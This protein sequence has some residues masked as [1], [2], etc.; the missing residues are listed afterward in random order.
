MNI[1]ST[2]FVLPLNAQGSNGAE[3][4]ADSGVPSVTVS[5]ESIESFN[6]LK[7]GKKLKY[8]IYKLSDD[9]TEIVVEDKSAEDEWDVFRSKLLSAKS[10][11]KGKESNGP[12]YAVY[13]FEYDAPGGEGRRYVC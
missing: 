13:D 4:Q 3:I 6:D 2:A 10:V 5:Q 12:R 8:I 7:L 11:H 9:Y 1:F